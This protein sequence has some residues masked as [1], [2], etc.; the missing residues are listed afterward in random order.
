MP[1]QNQVQGLPPGAVVG[2]PMQSQPAEVE[3][4]PP[5]AVVGPSMDSGSSFRTGTPAAPL[6]EKDASADQNSPNG[7]A[8]SIQATHIFDPKTQTIAK[9]P[10]EPGSRYSGLYTVGDAVAAQAKDRFGS[11][12]GEPMQPPKFDSQTGAL[13]N[14]E[15][16]DQPIVPD[17]AVV[18]ALGK[19]AAHIGSEVVS[20]AV[21][22]AKNLVPSAE[23]AGQKMEKLREAVGT[24]PVE[25]TEGLSKATARAQE[26]GDSQTIPVSVR[27]FINRVTDPDKG[28]LTYNEARDF[29]TK[30]GSM[31]ADEAT[32]LA[33]VVKGQI[34]TMASELKSSIAATAERAGKLED[35]QSSMRE[36][37]AAKKLQNVVDWVKTEGV[38]KALQGAAGA[39]GAA[40]GGYGA[41]KLY[42]ELKDLL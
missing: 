30:F 2:P 37:A 34:Q 15:V 23:R 16:E 28:H 3:G 7:S 22:K 36:Y 19:D 14:G 1:D 35:F 27:K 20:G 26:L 41:Y 10:V 32:K 38:K 18:E 39:T 25:M 8:A 33:P 24:H 9:L 21:Q 42:Q 11:H 29:L 13:T 17:A 4:L 31:T 40:A 6:S 12:A 5:G